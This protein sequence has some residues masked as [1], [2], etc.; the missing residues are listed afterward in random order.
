MMSLPNGRAD[1]CLYALH[2]VILSHMKTGF[3]QP[4]GVITEARE[5]RHV[6]IEV[7]A[8][9]NSRVR[10]VTRLSGSLVRAS[11]FHPCWF[12]NILQM[13]FK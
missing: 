13:F 12:P 1:I 6:N 4:S 9:N 10:T 7:L 5:G 3:M 8:Q 2:M 11:V